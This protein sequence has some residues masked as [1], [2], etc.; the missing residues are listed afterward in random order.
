MIRDAADRVGQRRDVAEPLKHVLPLAVGEREA[1]AE[2]R[3]DALLG[4][5]RHVLRV[6]G[7]DAVPGGLEAGGRAREP[8]VLL[9]GR[10]LGRHLARRSCRARERAH[11]VGE[12]GR[13][14]SCGAVSVGSGRHLGVFSIFESRIESVV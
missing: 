6:G 7:E 4:G 5:A 3:F 2:R 10:E 9:A 12:S 8:I 11:L 13:F 14:G 1:S